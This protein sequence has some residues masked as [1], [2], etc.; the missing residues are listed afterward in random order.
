MFG[1]NHACRPHYP[2]WGLGTPCEWRI[3]RGTTDSL[4]L[5]GIGN[6]SRRRL[7]L[8]NEH[9]HL[10][11]PHGDWEQTFGAFA[12]A[13]PSASLPL[14]GIGN[15][16][17]AEAVG[18]DFA[19]S[20]PLMGIGNTLRRWCFRWTGSATHYPSWGLGTR[21]GSAVAGGVRVGLIT[22]HGDWEPN[23]PGRQERDAVKLITPHGDWERPTWSA[24]A[25]ARISHYPSW[26][27]GT[28]ADD[29]RTDYG[30]ELITPHG[31]WEPTDRR[32]PVKQPYPLIT[33]HGDWELDVG[34][35][36][37]GGRG[38]ITP[39]GDWERGPGAG[40]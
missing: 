27:L 39:H 17:G 12:A 14:M 24:R 2:S 35:D 25:A 23:A 30:H 8:P 38:L 3:A 29:S 1:C 31:D 18:A 10:I 26:G 33:P 22:P 21:S 19:G 5:M 20:L 4:P 34:D 15:L 16:P 11:T 7:R 40:R 13:E 9:V 32:L 36:G 37:Y 28:S 6:A